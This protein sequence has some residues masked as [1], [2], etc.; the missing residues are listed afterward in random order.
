MLNSSSSKGQGRTGSQGHPFWQQHGLGLASVPRG[1]A[2]DSD[3]PGC[4][5]L[6]QARRAA[7]SSESSRHRP[8]CS[9]GS[10]P[11]V[12]LH[13]MDRQAAV[14]PS[15]VGLEVMVSASFALRGP[16]RAALVL[17]AAYGMNAQNGPARAA[18]LTE[19]HEFSSQVQHYLLTKSS[20][21]IP[22]LSSSQPHHTVRWKHLEVYR[23]LKVQLHVPHLSLHSSPC[24]LQLSISC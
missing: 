5:E 14:K 17:P 16:L 2:E 8:A 21:C 15:W 11:S 7:P 12:P 19:K 20:H 9:L 22:L 23:Y 6:S 4:P 1:T 10:S 3:S 18:K 24:K 13:W